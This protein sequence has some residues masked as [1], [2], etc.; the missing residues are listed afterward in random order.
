M[1]ELLIERP[2]TMAKRQEI[3]QAYARGILTEAQAIEQLQ[4]KDSHA[5]YSLLER[6]CVQE[7]EALRK[8]PLADGEA[9]DGSISDGYA[10]FWLSQNYELEG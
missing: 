6:L 2:M 1:G 4:L 9:A 3:L 8:A 5:F 10:S 7:W